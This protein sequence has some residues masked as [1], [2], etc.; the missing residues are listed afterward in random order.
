MGAD[1]PGGTVTFLFTDIEGSTAL[2]HKLGAERYAAALAEH[3]RALRGAFASHG[4]VEVDTQG[5]AF[6]YAFPAVPG[7]VLAA[8]EGQRA[9]ASGPI[10]VRMGMH[11]GTP[12]LTL[13]GYVG[14]DVHRAARIA[15][16]AHGGQVV[17]SAATAALAGS[18]EL[19]DLGHHRLKD[20]SAPERIYQLGA[21]NFPP[22]KSL[23][24]TNL[25]VP[26]TPFLGRERELAEVAT[27]L[28]SPAARLITLTGPGGTGKTRLAMQAAGR[29]GE[30]YPE[31]IYWVPLAA[32]TDPE[33]VL[34]VA[35]ASLNATGDVRAWIGDKRLLLLLDNFE[36]V[37]AAAD[38]LASLL[39]GCPQLTLLVTSR[40]PLHLT[41][42]QQ[43]PVPPLA[44]EE[45]VELF[46]TRARSIDPQFRPHPAIQQI[47]RQLDDL[48]LALELAAARVKA[49]TP[50]QLLHRLAERLPLL[51]SG[52]RDAPERH[53]T[54][55]ATIAWSYDLL[56]PGERKLYRCLAI[57]AGGST[58]TAAEEVAGADLDVLQSLLD[59]CLLQHTGERFWMLETIREYALDQLRDAG[60]QA[61]A[62]RRH[63]EYF[64][65]LAASANL[66][67]EAM[68]KGQHHELVIPEAA[69][70]RAAIDWAVNA[71]ETELAASTAVALEQYWVTNSPYE[72]L[73]R[74]DQL[75][76]L[77]GALPP[78]LAA[79]LLRVHGGV[80]II[81]GELEEGTRSYEEALEQF[82]AIGN[83]EAVAQMTCRLAFEA[84]RRGD[85]DRARALC[86][87]AL[88]LPHSRGVEAQ[89]LT[90]LGELA[91][92]EGRGQEALELLAESAKQ[93]GA[94]GFRWWEVIAL[95]VLAEYA[96]RLDQ[97]DV[98]ADAAR[99][100]LRLAYAIQ[101]RQNVVYALTVLAWLASK[102]GQPVRSGRLWGAIEAEAQ[103]G[104]I[105]QWEKERDEYARQ[106]IQ[107][108][109]AFERARKK[110]QQLTLEQ[111]VTE[112]LKA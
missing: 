105:G 50:D 23:Y 110:G 106:V 54:L 28:T 69:N 40:E 84:S 59:K 107:A 56:P 91:F 99:K 79:Q 75:V 34:E 8:A 78:L 60:E 5:D 42:E 74:L 16:A 49:L 29:C 108:T 109:A 47:C 111:A 21:G 68:E 4:G 41:G 3:R 70:L 18:G 51:T 15:A 64:L 39:S 85:P 102:N 38:G 81:A 63:A 17:V 66:T 88:Q 22:L 53:R 35:A 112:G 13:E 73:R 6:F 10:R 36:Q 90:Q 93:A 95:T 30:H 94:A 98:A 12:Y 26:A 44:P 71:S 31:G 25:P 86:T 43:Y 7:A 67:D 19:K 24:R 1:L 52:A 96:L 103:R 104:T 48:P 2:L 89:L 77:K 58:L 33:L 80:S 97:L 72:G 61:A 20:L 83:D 27:L 37:V 76:Q 92:A 87:R 11:T 45:G 55:R 14:A 46:M 100:G 32:L 62:G 82:Q 65:A 101:D 9:L 57:F